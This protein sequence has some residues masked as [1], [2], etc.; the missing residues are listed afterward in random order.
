MRKK[1]VLV[2][3]LTAL[4]FLSTAVLGVSFVYRV[5]GVV[6]TAPVVSESAKTEAED[7]Q[8]RLQ[9]AYEDDSMFFVDSAKAEKIVAEFPYFRLTSFKKDYPNEIRVVITEDA[10]VYATPVSGTEGY[11]YILNA[12]GIVLGT[13]DSYV[14]RSTL[15]NNVLW[16]GLT[17]SGTHGQ[18]LTGDECIPSLLT[19]SN[20]VIEQLG[21]VSLNLIS[22]D[23]L[24]PASAETIFRLSMIEGVRIYVRNPAVLT[25]EKAAAA[26]EKYLQLDDGQRL[27]GMI[28]VDTLLDSEE[29][30]V[31]YTPV[32]AFA[33]V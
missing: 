24:R 25:S 11:Y 9:T 10:E 12:D 14:N 18:T 33:G 13:R 16:T 31:S 28:M 21:N 3:L 15:E 4:V 22:V 27:K 5:D 30:I 7:L 2:I 17:T 23:V 8:K 26:I 29:I 19:F 20:R 32:D 1:I 6:L